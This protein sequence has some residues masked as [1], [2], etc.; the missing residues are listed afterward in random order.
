MSEQSGLSSSE[1]QA[2]L[3]QYGE[4]AIAEQRTNLLRKF[5]LYFWGPIPW[6]IEIAAILSAL[7]RHWEDFAII[8]IMLLLY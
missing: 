3:A 8:A 5:L 1:A 7:V 4:N 2:R 6:M